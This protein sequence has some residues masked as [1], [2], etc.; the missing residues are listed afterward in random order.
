MT[1]EL[2]SVDESALVRGLRDIP[3]GP[4]RDELVGLLKELVEFVRDP[5]C[6]E[7]QGDGVPCTTTAFDCEQCQRVADALSRLHD[8]LRTF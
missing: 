5:R 3:A 8:R 4:A 7:A 1:P 6:V 2:L